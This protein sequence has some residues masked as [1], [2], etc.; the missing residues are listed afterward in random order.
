MSPSTARATREIALPV[1]GLTTLREALRDEAGPVAAVNSLHAAGFRAGEEVWLGIC[2]GD[3]AATRALS[4]T[5]F[6]STVGEWFG[7]RGWGTLTFEAIHPGIGRLES[8]D[9]AEA[10][11]GEERQPSCAFTTGMFSS[12]LSAAAGG[13]VAAL[14]ISCRA[15][16]DDACRWVFGSETTVHQLYGSLLEGRPL[17]D[18]LADLE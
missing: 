17:E 15:R 7:R 11:G 6:W 4:E 1:S 14:E 13:S 2:R 9:W 10:E 18:A 8:G 5:A 16:G 12:L 3:E